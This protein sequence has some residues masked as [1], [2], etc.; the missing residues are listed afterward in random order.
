MAVPLAEAL[1]KSALWG[2]EVLPEW[3]F[4]PGLATDALPRC[5]KCG[6]E[7]RLCVDGSGEAS[8]EKMLA[9]RTLKG[10]RGAVMPA[11][12]LALAR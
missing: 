3:T 10:D 11:L 12:I 8:C 6:C 7:D 2:K 5:C 9:E 4:G 1:R